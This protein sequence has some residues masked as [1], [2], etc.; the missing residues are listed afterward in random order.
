MTKEELNEYLK[1]AQDPIYFLDNYGK[2]LDITKEPVQL[3]N[4]KCFDYQREILKKFQ[5]FQNNI[6]LKSRQAGLSV[7]T[8]GFVVWTLL[9][10]NDQKVLII[11]NDRN[12]AIRFLSTVKQYL[13][14]LPSFLLPQDR[15]KS[16]E[17]EIIFSNKNSVK[18]VAAGKNAGR[19]ETPTLLILDE[20]AFIENA[21]SIWTAASLSLS[22]TKGK[23]IMISTPFGTGNLYHKT[24]V[25]AEAGKNDFVTTKIHWTQ[26]PV[27]SEKKEEKIDEF[28]QHSWTSPWYEF[29]CEQLNNDRVKIAQELDLSFEGSRALVIDSRIIK[30]Y[31]DNILGHEEP[32]CYYNFRQE[33][34]GWSTIKTDFWVWKKPVIGTNY[35]VAGDVGRG[36]GSD[37]ST[38]QVIDADNL[39]QVAEYQGK[40]PPDVF[41]QII[42]KICTEYNKAYAVIECNS[43]GLAT[44][45]A[46]KNQLGYDPMRIYH[47]KSIN[48]LVNHHYGVHADEA[49]EIPGFQ[50]T[51]LT[52]PLIIT[53]LGTNMREGIIKIH[54]TR[55]LN[56][57]DTFIYLDGIKA[58][59]APGFHDDLIIALG[60]G[61]FIREK[62]FENVFLNREFYQQMFGAVSY[63]NGQNYIANDPNVI[64]NEYKQKTQEQYKIPNIQNPNSTDDEDLRWLL[65]NFINPL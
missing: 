13:D 26:H 53:A 2:V 51:V 50:T 16:N 31:K 58:Q 23:C 59:H 15:E 5:K 34:S 4:L 12:G 21:E 47:S 44:T 63:S 35:I 22:G 17:S 6:V 38:L 29:H 62:E 54:S 52:R 65:G 33:G 46:L 49:D 28:G 60:I 55:L 11:A 40:I 32:I 41:A 37:F 18:A 56:E 3:N 48:K 8:A 9:F 7:I 24:W 39:E 19:G 43:F 30:K 36:D 64:A 25:S 27:Y 10:K 61:L 42:Y 1:C 57:F 45:L 14:Y 20:T